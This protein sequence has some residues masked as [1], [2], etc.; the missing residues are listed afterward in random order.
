MRLWMYDMCIVYYIKYE[1]CN[2]I[3]IPNL[4][5]YSKHV[6]NNYPVE[7]II[8]AQIPTIIY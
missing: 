8:I 1:R 4:I 5:Y 3:L 6:I 2:L 7:I